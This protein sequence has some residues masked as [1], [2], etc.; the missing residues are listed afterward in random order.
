MGI[1]VPPSE[2]YFKR[3][4]ENHIHHTMG[5]ILLCNKAF[6][7]VQFSKNISTF[8]EQY[9]WTIFYPRN[10]QAHKLL[11]PTHQGFFNNINNVPKFSYKF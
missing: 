5:N 11:N 3:P 6:W 8:N 7:F 10:F 2:N 4:I 9:F 1:G